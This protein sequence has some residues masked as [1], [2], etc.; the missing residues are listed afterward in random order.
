MIFFFFT[1]IVYIHFKMQI[2]DQI[3]KYL[4]LNAH[5]LIFR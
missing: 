1:E 5:K 4:I 2:A 3:C